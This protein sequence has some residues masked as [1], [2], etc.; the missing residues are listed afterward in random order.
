MGNLNTMIS[1]ILFLI[2]L[3]TL[4]QSPTQQDN[5]KNGYFIVQSDIGSCEINRGILE[6]LGSKATNEDETV[7]IIARLG[8]K[9]KSNKLNKQRLE[10]AR[11]AL[12]RVMPK[13]RIILAESNPISSEGRVEF[14]FKGKLFLVSLVQ[15]N[16]N[17]CTDF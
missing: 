10:S 15:K 7:I 16:K 12:A 5:T 2:A 4:L 14:Y 3:V 6:H 1:K 17:L 8:I 9:E 11:F 13:E